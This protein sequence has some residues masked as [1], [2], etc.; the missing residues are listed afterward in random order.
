MFP[1]L[2]PGGGQRWLA[3]PAFSHSAEDVEFCLQAGRAIAP[4]ALSIAT[5]FLYSWVLGL[6]MLKIKWWNLILSSPLHSKTRYEIPAY[7]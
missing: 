5:L 1:A 4:P 7:V 6:S 3:M 2:L